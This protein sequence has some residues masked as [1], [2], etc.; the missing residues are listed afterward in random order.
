MTTG[1]VRGYALPAYSNDQER[2]LAQS[3]RGTLITINEY[4]QWVEAG[5]IF[6]ASIGEGG[7]KVD[8]AEVAYD[9]DQPQ[10]ALDVPAGTTVI[11]LKVQF[12]LEEM[13]GT[14]NTFI[15]AT[16]SGLIAAGTSTANTTAQNMNTSAVSTRTTNTTFRQLYTGNGTA[17]ANSAEFWMH[18]EPLAVSAESHPKI[19]WNVMTGDLPPVI[20][21]PA[22][23]VGYVFATTDGPEGHAKLIWAEFES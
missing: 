22:A 4:M 6:A 23:L 13:A 1:K 8:F 3:P 7:T 20:V 15:L 10:F 14:D 12:V 18:E 5:H 11:P 9:A 2:P 17:P 19:E 16:S 21:G